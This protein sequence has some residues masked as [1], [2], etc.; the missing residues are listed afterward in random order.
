MTNVALFDMDG[1][2][3]DYVGA[4][5]RNLNMLAGPNEENITADNLYALEQKAYIHNRMRL[6]KQQPDFWL[7]LEPIEMGM[8]ALELAKKVGFDIHILTKGPKK[9]AAAWKEK[10]EWCQKHLG[11]VDIH[12]TSDK[13]L[14]YGKVL[15]DDYPEYMLRWLK[16]RSRGLGIMPVTMY[17]RD[18]RHPNVVMWDGTNIV[19]LTYA[20]V[21]AFNRQ[22]GEELVWLTSPKN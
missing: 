16:Y 8:Q 5:A 14:V 18:F 9:I 6:I 4:L 1:S 19:E 12:I 21:A 15:Y 10:V 22:S 2:L 20:L 3:A 11:D 7:N 13:G 17:N